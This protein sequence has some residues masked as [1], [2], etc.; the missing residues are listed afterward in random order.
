MES[1]LQTRGITQSFRG[2]RNSK[3]KMC[4]NVQAKRDWPS[5]PKEIGVQAVRVTHPGKSPNV[6]LVVK[7]WYARTV[8]SPSPPFQ[9]CIAGCCY[10]ELLV[11]SVLV[12]VSRCTIVEIINGSAPPVGSLFCI[13]CQDFT[14]PFGADCRHGQYV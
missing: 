7:K 8:V 13:M 5:R 3:N 1:V 11:L 4:K 10:L 9:P 2:M 14:P 6:M 12:Y